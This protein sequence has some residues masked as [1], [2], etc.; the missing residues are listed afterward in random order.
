MCFPGPKAAALLICLAAAP[1]CRVARGALVRLL[2]ADLDSTSSARHALRQ[3]LLRLRG[4]LGAAADVIGADPEMIWLDRESVQIDLVAVRQAIRDG[5]AARICDLSAST[6]GVFCDGLDLTA[7][8]WEDW[9]RSERQKAE[10]LC[11]ALHQ[12]ASAELAVQGRTDEALAAANR[13]VRAEPYEEAAH[14]ALV[15]LNMQSGRRQAAVQARVAC[16][17]LFRRDLGV[18][19]GESLRSAMRPVDSVRSLPVTAVP[20][21]QQARPRA[22]VAVY[23]SLAAAMI[24]ATLSQRGLDHADPG[25][26]DDPSYVMQPW[27][28]AAAAKASSSEGQDRSS[29]RLEGL[30]SDVRKMLEGDTNYAML[31][32]VGC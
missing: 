6:G 5:D 15:A 26:A 28:T 27:I 22:N 18:V 14:A 19:P 16:I 13:R 31:Y 17:E 7:H 12:M 29:E 30:Q 1:S 10:R 9:V 23:A 8:E 4:S 32:P 24:V 20:A 21:R 11:A 2:W 3:C 25:R